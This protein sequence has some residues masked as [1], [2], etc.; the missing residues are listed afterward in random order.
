MTQP[1]RIWAFAGVAIACLLKPMGASAS[2]LGE[3]SARPLAYQSAVATSSHSATNNPFEPTFRDRSEPPVIVGLWKVTF[4][5]GG[6]VTDVGFDAWH[7]DGT[8]ILN[9]VSTLSHNVCLG[10]WVQVAGRTFKLKHM[11]LRFD[12]SGNYIGNAI[13]RETAVVNRA[14]NAYTG[15]FTL[16]FLDLDGNSVFTVSGEIAGERVTVD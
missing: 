3:M 2:C 9:D 13:L 11:V 10:T 16:E 12:A 1:F 4:T 7:D 8:E 14:G 5:S 15:S 6:E